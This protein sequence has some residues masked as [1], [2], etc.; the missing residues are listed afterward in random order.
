MRWYEFGSFWGLGQ[1][2]KQWGVSQIPDRPLLAMDDVNDNVFGSSAAQILRFGRSRVRRAFKWETR[3]GG[4]KAGTLGLAPALGT[5][6]IFLV[7]I[8]CSQKWTLK[9]F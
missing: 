7:A 3:M 4:P 9:M 5:N 1:E 8:R 6:G 2:K